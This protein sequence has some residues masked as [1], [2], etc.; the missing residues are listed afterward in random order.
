MTV[1]GDPRPGPDAGPA[2]AVDPPESTVDVGTLVQRVR[3]VFDGG[4]TRSIDWRHEQLDGL[5]RMLDRESDALS[6]AMATD[7]GKPV[8]EGWAADIG[9]T[10]AEIRH[11][12]RHV[13]RWAAPRRARLPLSSRPA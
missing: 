2:E 7:L 3:H 1:A 6:E 12:R 5:L 4:R 9:T 8:L 11:L 13:R 10:A